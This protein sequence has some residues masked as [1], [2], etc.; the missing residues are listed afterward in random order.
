MEYNEYQLEPNPRSLKVFDHQDNIY[1]SIEIG[2]GQEGGNKVT[3]EKQIL[4]RGNLSQPT[5]IGKVSEL[6][7]KEI[8]IE[9]IVLDV[10]QY[11]NMCVITTSFLNQENKILFT[12]IDK[13]ESPEGGLAIF[14]GKYILSALCLF[15][16]FGFVELKAQN[17]TDDISF[18]NL[19]TPSSPG[20][21][22]LDNTPSSIERP[23]TPQGFGVSVLGL[24]QGTGGAIEFAPFWLMTHPKLTGKKMYETKFPLLQNLSISAATIKTDSSNYLAGGLRARIYQHYSKG[25]DDTLNKIRE[26]ITEEL[27]KGRD[28]IDS[29]KI[30]ELR[31]IYVNV[32]QKPVFNIDFA[33][34]FGS[35]SLTN[36]FDNLEFNRWAA[37]L[38]FNLRPKGDDFYF[39]VL[40][41]YLSNGNIK[42]YNTSENLIDIGTRFNYDISKFCISLEYLQRM[43]F[44]NKTYDDY[45]IAVIG[46]YKLT[47]NFFITSTFGK[48][49]TNVNN[50]IALAGINF[51]FSKV[52]TKAY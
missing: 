9:T 13:G 16:S 44:T 20:F 17:S 49:F 3:S 8:C 7:G 36:S 11:T 1:L 15:L 38:S 40:S 43:N 42:E 4:T 52:K 48:N 32:T 51:G 24:F 28:S 47:D 29:N 41:R 30:T 25:Q 50:I 5:Y 23:T 19:E 26:K 34:A 31:Q 2:N 33:V 10:N 22:L 14:L 37:W 21:I 39:T 35:I 27:S 18:Q 45:R 46:S 6:T 12:K